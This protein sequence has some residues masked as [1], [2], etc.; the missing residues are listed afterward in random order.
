[1]AKGTPCTYRFRVPAGER[2]E[3][4]DMIR[5]KVGCYGF[6]VKDQGFKI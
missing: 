6:K 2:I 5:G 4:D 3:I 1:M